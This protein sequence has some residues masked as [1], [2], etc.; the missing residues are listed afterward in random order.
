MK[1]SLST[2]RCAIAVALTTTCLIV[3]G[4]PTNVLGQASGSIGT[5]PARLIKT[6]PI[7]SP[8]IQSPSTQ[9]N[10]AQ[11]VDFEAEYEKLMDEAAGETGDAENATASSTDPQ[12]NATEEQ[13]RL[14]AEQQLKQKRLQKIAKLTFDRRPST[15][16]KVWSVPREE[17]EKQLKEAY[18]KAIQ[19]SASAAKANSTTTEPAKTEK[20]SN[21][22]L[23]PTGID[24]FGAN[25]SGSAAGSIAARTATRPRAPLPKPLPV[26]TGT[27]TTG[28]TT[29]GTTTT[30]T[31]TIS[32]ATLTRPA[33][34]GTAI[35]AP[36]L[37][38]GLAPQQTASTKT[39]A[40]TTATQADVK[41]DTAQADAKPNDAANSNAANSNAAAANAAQIQKEKL[42]AYDREL[43][44]L[45]RNVTLGNWADVKTFLAAQ[46][47]SEGKAIFAKILAS[48]RTSVALAPADLPEQFR[49]Q[50]QQLLASR[51]S[52]SARKNVEKHVFSFQDIVDLADASPTEI[53]KSILSGLAAIILG[54]LQ[55]GNDAEELM[56]LLHKV[57]SDDVEKDGEQK[58]GIVF[59]NR[60]TVNL[61]LFARKVIEAGECLPELDQAIADKDHEALNL[62]SRYYLALHKKE[63]KPAL[64]EKAWKVTQTVL[65]ETEVDQLQKDEALKRAVE[66]APKVESELGAAW[67]EESFADRPQRGIEILATIGIDTSTGMIRRGTDISYRLRALQ[68][69]AT[70]VD[71]LLKFTH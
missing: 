67:L 54:T 52:S 64:L 19:T 17:F 46:E 5:K 37:A 16:L 21:E 66:L 45:K 25:N 35:T 70:A 20:S 28:T 1:A 27:T 23:P 57:S 63:Q 31:T 42:A 32:T 30:G 6:V 56:S 9:T 60:Q 29:T 38:A 40:T 50:Y 4:S 22:V 62:L 18:E 24:P 12:A 53:D 3:T 26:R 39:D 43:A 51:N 59:T 8:S 7:Q 11:Q 71:A 47:E 34:A 10:A 33:T 41:T 58:E 49:A 44:I 68:L 13:K 14:A 55:K 48:F 2:R 61:L 15:I 36:A 69:Q 65:S